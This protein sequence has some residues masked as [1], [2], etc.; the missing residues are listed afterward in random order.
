MSYPLVSVIIPTYNRAFIVMKAIESA[1]QQ[2]YPNVEVLVIDD[3]SE[4][5]TEQLVSVEKRVKYIKI[6]HGGQSTA[7]NVGLE[8]SQGTFIAPLDSDDVWTPDFLMKCVHAIEHFRLDFVFANWLQEN[9]I[10]GPHDFLCRD[11]FLRPYIGKDQVGDWML[12]SSDDLRKLYLSACPSPSS[13][14]VIRKSS[15]AGRY[16]KLLRIGEDWS[17]YLDMILNKP[18]RAA[19]TL[20]KLWYKQV[21][22]HN[23]YDGRVRNQVLEIMN[24][25]DQE[26]LN[27]Y[28]HLLRDDEIAVF[29]KKRVSVMME[30]A[31][32]KL[33]RERR[34]SESWKLYKEA[35]MLQPLRAVMEIPSLMSQAFRNRLMKLSL[36]FNLMDS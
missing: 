31:K 19:F 5:H 17:L 18:C 36:F 1:L 23:I 26:I 6:P 10:G 12:L 24:V 29:T 13:S 2:T 27:L 28:Q 4:D 9:K 34:F 15:I 33:I 22:D 20:E 32:H 14:T 35:F 11:P 21:H 3:G 7:R 25:D 8:L 16:N 30:L